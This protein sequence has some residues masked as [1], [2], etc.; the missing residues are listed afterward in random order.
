MT[1]RLPI[2][3]KLV[4]FVVALLLALSPTFAFAQ[5]ATSSSNVALRGVCLRL[6]SIEQLMVRRLQDADTLY[7]RSVQERV[8][9]SSAQSAQ[10]D[11][12]E[13][14]LRSDADQK[15]VSYI[16]A[17]TAKADTQAKSDAVKAF[18]AKVQAAEK[19]RRSAIDAAQQ[20]FWND[21][22][23][24]IDARA[25]SVLQQSTRFKSDVSS[26]IN[27]AN[28]HCMQGMDPKMVR[29]E[30]HK[31][32]LQLQEMYKNSTQN[33]GSISGSV[34][35]IVQMRMEAIMAANNAFS[36]EI[37]GAIQQLRTVL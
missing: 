37:D 1:F 29:D 26:R 32:L 20:A 36:A 11:V 28:T 5:G 23:S 13:Q 25:S 4:T 24:L 35:A 3:L 6:T 27:E 15:F 33:S 14:Q 9:Q 30:L 10:S 22:K 21:I 8:N 12:T 7:N 2:Q 16:E 31:S 18:K 34:S 19:V 17:Q